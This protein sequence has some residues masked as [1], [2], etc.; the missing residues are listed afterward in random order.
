MSR[1]PG[2]CR[3]SSSTANIAS[4]IAATLVPSGPLIPTLNSPSSTFDGAYS[5]LTLPYSGIAESIT[6]T[7]MT[8][9]TQRCAIACLSSHVYERSMYP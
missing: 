5:C 4:F 3:T 6:D 2:T 8:T 1:T 7:A 9:T